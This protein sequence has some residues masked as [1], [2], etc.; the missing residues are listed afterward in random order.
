MKINR[1]PHTYILVLVLAIFGL[2]AYALRHNY[3]VRFAIQ[4]FMVFEAKRPK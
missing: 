4:N 2:C 1:I 3:N